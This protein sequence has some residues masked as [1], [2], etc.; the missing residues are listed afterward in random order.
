MMRAVA[1]SPSLPFRVLRSSLRAASRVG[2]NVV[3]RV[4]RRDE[5]PAPFEPP[6]FARATA[7]PERPVEVR[8]GGVAVTVPAGT[9][10]LEAARR[11]DVDL[12]S[13]CGGN[14]SC[15]TCRVEIAETF[16]RGLSR[17]QPMEDLVLGGEAAARGDRLACQAQVQ[18]DVEVHVP[19]WF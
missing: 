4:L 10:I 1:D 12:R 18:G 14:C 6:T 8:F 7:R 16:R 9:T 5:A 17:R 13:Y 3:E 2:S 19:A 11:A 15:G